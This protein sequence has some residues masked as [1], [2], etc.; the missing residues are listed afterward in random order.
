[1]GQRGGRPKEYAQHGQT[2]GKLTSYSPAS[3]EYSSL[4]LENLSPF[5]NPSLKLELVDALLVRLEQQSIGYS[6]CGSSPCSVSASH[7]QGG[8]C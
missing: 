3:L 1:M 8:R 2:K 6:T 7:P 5:T 4:E